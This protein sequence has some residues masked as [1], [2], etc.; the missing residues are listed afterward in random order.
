[1]RADRRHAGAAPLRRRQRRAVA[2]LGEPEH[3]RAEDAV[4][5]QVLADPGLDRAK[6]L[7][8]R[9]CASARSRSG[10]RADRGLVVVAHVRAP[11]RGLPGRNPPQAH[12]AHHVID[13]QA[14][15]MP[16]RGGEQ[17]GHRLVVVRRQ[18]AR[19]PRR[20]SP[21]L[22]ELVEAVRRGAHA[23][24][25]DEQARKRPGVG[26]ARM[27][28][29]SQVVDDAVGHPRCCRR[30]LG[31]GEL[32]VR[33][34]LQPGMELC[35]LRQLRIVGDH[36]RGLVR[37]GDSGRPV[38]RVRAV[39][40]GKRAPLRPLLKAA[41]AVPAEPVVG[42]LPRRR[43]RDLADELE[44]LP[45]GRPDGVPVDECGCVAGRDER[46]RL[47]GRPRPCRPG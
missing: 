3:H 7:A 23:E 9:D 33:L 16:Q 6:V 11:F 41:A 30:V 45:L 42:L 36:I 8:D 46:G 19:V 34:P 15:A 14:A 29:D 13:A 47:A 17:L 1:M 37:A 28:A 31:C 25:L 20:L 5:G 2:G 35:R 38:P 26:T 39:P 4:A 10:E 40:L 32:L 22:S 44:R 18:Q 12:E 43:Q 24:V 27:H 21:V